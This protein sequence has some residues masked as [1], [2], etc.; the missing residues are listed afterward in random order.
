[1][2]PV[3]ECDRAQLRSSIEQRNAR[4]YG[5]LLNVSRWLRRARRSVDALVVLEARSIYRD[6]FALKLIL[7]KILLLFNRSSSFMDNAALFL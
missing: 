5:L 6:V 1:M 3:S 4:L 7:Q 2:L